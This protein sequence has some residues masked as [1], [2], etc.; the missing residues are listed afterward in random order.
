MLAK[1]P[2]DSQ[3]FGINVFRL[4]VSELDST[5]FACVVKDFD[6]A[7]PDIV[8]VRVSDV[9][10]INFLGELSEAFR[11]VIA[12]SLLE[13]CLVF[14]DKFE[15][16]SGANSREIRD[17]IRLGV[18]EDESAV[19]RVASQAFLSHRSHYHANPLFSRSLINV[20]YEDWAANEL[21]DRN[22]FFVYEDNDKNIK[23]FLSLQIRNLRGTVVLNAVDPQFAGLGIYQALL[24][25]ALEFA[26]DQD[27]LDVKIMTPSTN[28]RPINVWIKLGFRYSRLLHTI[29]VMPSQD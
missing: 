12:D 9:Q 20:G 16:L 6:S 25:T 21:R 1:S 5:K 27:C 10:L 24:K 28:I 13:F 23:G 17:H 4:D 26:S 11:F 8:I 3:R 18:P 15:H 14:A 7:Q 22:S 19:R 2:L 29:H